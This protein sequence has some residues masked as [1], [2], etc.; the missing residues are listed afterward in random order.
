[1]PAKAACGQPVPCRCTPTLCGSEPAREGGFK[2]TN[3][4]RMYSIHCGSWLASEGASQPT[5]TLLTKYAR[6]QC[7][8]YFLSHSQACATICSNLA[9]CGRQPSSVLA[10][11]ASA[12]NRGG[13]PARREA[14]LM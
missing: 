2:P 4:S 10:L 13:S 11:D 9:Y 3:R 6:L 5:R 1:M 12:T 14:S 8:G 7:Q